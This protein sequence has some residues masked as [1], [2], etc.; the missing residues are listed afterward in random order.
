MVFTRLFYNTHKLYFIGALCALCHPT[1]MFSLN[2]KHEMC[3]KYL[4][5]QR[6]GRKYMF[7]F[8]SLNPPWIVWTQTFSVHLDTV[9]SVFRSTVKS[10]CSWLIHTVELRALTSIE[11]TSASK[12]MCYFRHFPCTP[13]PTPLPIFDSSKKVNFMRLKKWILWASFIL[14]P[15]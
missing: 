8:P 15:E 14:P 2:L 13:A 5:L 6:V 7:A 11:N 4:S 1:L 3:Q 9:L 10:L 12:K